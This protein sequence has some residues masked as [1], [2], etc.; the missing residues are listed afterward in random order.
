MDEIVKRAMDLNQ[1]DIDAAPAEVS[2]EA[3]VAVVAVTIAALAS[4]AVPKKREMTLHVFHH[5]V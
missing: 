2:E 1:A 3:V 4:L 5:N